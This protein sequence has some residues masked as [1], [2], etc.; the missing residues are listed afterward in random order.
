ML[1][2]LSTVNKN[3]PGGEHTQ[4]I[5]HVYQNIEQPTAERELT[6][7]QTGANTT[8]PPR[9]C[10]ILREVLMLL[11]RML[12]E[13][14][15]LSPPP[16]ATQTC[17]PG[18]ARGSPGSRYQIVLS[19]HVPAGIGAVPPDSHDGWLSPTSQPSAV[20]VVVWST[21]AGSAMGASWWRL[22][23]R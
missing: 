14:A 19:L 6:R 13:F 21:L 10:I 7:L 16:P 18:G 23:R 1:F 9:L 8:A 15:G 4:L 20:P 11:M 12:V 5:Q 22:E 2:A 3:Q 17:V